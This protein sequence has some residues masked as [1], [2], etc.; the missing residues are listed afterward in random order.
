MERSYLDDNF[1]PVREELTVADLAVTG[2]IPDYLDGRYLRIGPNPVAA[3]D[4]Q[5]YHWFLGDGMVHG[6][7]L[8]DGQAQWYRNRYVRS[9]SVSDALGEP[10]RRD[11]RA[12]GGLDLSP[13]TNVI[14]QGGRTLALVE[15]GPRPY[16]LTEELETVGPCDFDGSLRG[17]YTA[18]PHRDPATGD[19][20]AISYFWGWGKRVR[21]T[22]TGVD[23]RVH[24]SVDIKVGGSPMI[25]DFSLT[26]NYV[27]IY[28]LPVTFD[29]ARVTASMP[30]FMRPMA[31]ATLAGVI[32]R[33]PI[34][35]PLTALMARTTSSQARYDA[36]SFPYSWDPTY[37]AR[38]GLL[39]R[40]G[41]SDDVRW[42]DVEPCYV[43][44]PLNAYEDGDT[45]VA[46]VVRHPKMF[47]SELRGPD[48]GPPSLDRWTIDL[49]AG[50]V[51]EQRL[52][53][54][55]QEFPR[56]DERLTG[57]RHRF[58][59]T[60]GVDEDD[61]CVIKHDLL[62]GDTTTRRFGRGSVPSE[63]AFVAEDPDSA[64]DQG[65][66]MG[67]VYDGETDRSDLTVL[68]AQTLETVASIHLP[69]RVPQGF[70]GN[71]IPS[72]G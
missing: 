15:A 23:G 27:V 67:Y 24:R 48:E 5:R 55:G 1:A 20:H 11:R 70:H 40:N 36:S 42:F 65:V 12:H 3:A 50:K 29:S 30:F 57:R 2:S 37:Q 71:W 21:Y 60:V 49:A 43:F 13:N 10:R 32:G 56:I 19:L 17:G 8:R 51:L 16:E 34:P 28:D 25:H 61:D 33:L 39:P 45:I 66:L 9:K 63:F 31:R 44:H 47:A 7:R 72:D 46:D 14:A 22:V 54:R 6:L 35:E 52:D 59:Y 4:P 58:G 53:D 69:A 38:I 18:H 26:E 64:E 68:D 41:G 62:S